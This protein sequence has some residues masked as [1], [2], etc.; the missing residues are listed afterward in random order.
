VRIYHAELKPDERRLWDDFPVT[1][2][3]RSLIDIAQGGDR[4]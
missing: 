3:E 2:V 1:T 4:A